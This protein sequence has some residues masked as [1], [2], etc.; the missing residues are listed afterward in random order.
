MSY[1]IT[2][3]H[4]LKQLPSDYNMNLK[5]DLLDKYFKQRLVYACNQENLNAISSSSETQHPLDR[6]N[7]RFIDMLRD[8]I[9]DFRLFSL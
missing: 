3:V 2:F 4:Y 8:D 9:V 7:A 6:F 1:C 5:K